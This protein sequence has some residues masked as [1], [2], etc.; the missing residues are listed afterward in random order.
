MTAGRQG[1]DI[2]GFADSLQ[3]GSTTAAPAAERQLQLVVFRLDREEFAVPI[4]AVREIVRAGDITR[5]PQAPADVRGV[6]NLRGRILPVVELRT[7][8]GLPPAELSARSRVL[9]TEAQSRAIGLL[10]DSV[11]EVV[12]LPESAVVPPPEEILSANAGYVSGVARHGARLLILLKL[13]RA[14]M[15]GSS[16][17]TSPTAL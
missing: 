16:T 3:A 8:L 11:A 6:M 1:Q 7:R 4:A 13:D 2:L 17:T 9:V 10:V 12:K 14:V 5:I 15:L